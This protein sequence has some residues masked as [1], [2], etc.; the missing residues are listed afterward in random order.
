MFS[1]L[2]HQKILDD[3][4]RFQSKITTVEPMIYAFKQ[5]TFKKQED[6]EKT[7]RNI[8]DEYN[9]NSKTVPNKDNLNI[10]FF[11]AYSNDKP[12]PYLGTTNTIK[13]EDIEKMEKSLQL[14]LTKL[15][16]NLYRLCPHKELEKE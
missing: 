7:I 11:V 14:E 1:V 4:N 13:D 10:V 2:T 15:T 3:L 12:V 16:D 6:F 5:G 8:N 9:G